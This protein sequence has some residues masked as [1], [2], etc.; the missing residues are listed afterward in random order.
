MHANHACMQIMSVRSD[1]FYFTLLFDRLNLTDT[2]SCFLKEQQENTSKQQNK[3]YKI[4]ALLY[5]QSGDISM[6]ISL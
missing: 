3:L 1:T 2:V 5:F 4:R 6:I